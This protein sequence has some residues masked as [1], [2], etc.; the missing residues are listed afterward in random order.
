MK[1]R[2]ILPDEM[3]RY[4]ARYAQLEPMLAMKDT[5]I[6]LEARDKI[7]SRELLPVASPKGGASPFGAAPVCDQ[8]FSITYAR[9]PPGPDRSGFLKKSSKPL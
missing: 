7:W 6:P 3:Q 5:D 4:V 9:C 2:E 1:T 8:D